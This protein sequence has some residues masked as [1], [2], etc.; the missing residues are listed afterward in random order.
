VAKLKAGLLFLSVILLA[1]CTSGGTA[2]KA[3]SVGATHVMRNGCHGAVHHDHA[4]DLPGCYAVSSMKPGQQ[5]DTQVNFTYFKACGRP[6][7]LPVY[8][9]PALIKGTAVTKGYPCEYFAKTTSSGYCQGDTTEGFLFH[10][11]CQ[12]HGQ[13]PP[14]AIGDT[15]LTDEAG[16]FSDIWDRIVIPLGALKGSK[17]PLVPSPDGEGYLEYGADLW[18]EN[19]GWHNIPC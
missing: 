6:C 12:V 1:S 7:W 14:G 15:N 5:F 8:P 10:V 18:L 9:Q 3:K 13:L 17:A 2:A 4:L 16:H 11:V 19:T